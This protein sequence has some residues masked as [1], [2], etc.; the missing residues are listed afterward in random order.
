MAQD[1]HREAPEAGPVRPSR[2]DELLQRAEELLR[3]RYGALAAEQLREGVQQ[4][5]AAAAMERFR[6]VHQQLADDAARAARPPA[7]SDPGLSAAQ[8]FLTAM[9]QRSAG[10]GKTLSP[11]LLARVALEELDG[12]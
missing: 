3:R 6:R 12:Q 9:K 2:R 11:R 8:H 10:Q 7:P 4:Q 1:L 5:Q